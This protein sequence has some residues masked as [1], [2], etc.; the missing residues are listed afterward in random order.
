[1]RCEGGAPP[2]WLLAPCGQSWGVCR[3]LFPLI[4]CV[5]SDSGHRHACH[6]DGCSLVALSHDI[7][8]QEQWAYKGDNQNDVQGALLCRAW[9]SLESGGG[10][11]FSVEGGS[12]L[13]HRR[14]VDSRPRLVLWVGTLSEAESSVVLLS[15]S[16]GENVG[17]GSIWK[18]VANGQ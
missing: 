14:A 5:A 9:P 16:K 18:Q 17:T 1:M 2:F 11:S 7:N 15:F 4:A 3:P 12:P 13:A 8:A 6:S 10:R